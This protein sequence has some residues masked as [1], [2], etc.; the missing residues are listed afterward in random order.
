MCVIMMQKPTSPCERFFLH[1]GFCIFLKVREKQW[2]CSKIIPKS[3]VILFKILNNTLKSRECV[4]QNACE[5]MY[6]CQGVRENLPC[7]TMASFWWQTVPS[8]IDSALFRT[9]FW[10]S[11]G[12][13]LLLLL[14]WFGTNMLEFFGAKRVPVKPKC[15]TM[16]LTQ[17][18]ILELLKQHC[19]EDKVN[20]WGIGSF[21]FKC[22][23]CMFFFTRLGNF[24]E[25]FFSPIH[26][27]S[28][29][30]CFFSSA[31][32]EDETICRYI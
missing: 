1:L 9:V 14:L 21:C 29:L 28:P 20:G 10:V 8:T 3:M 16:I 4:M 5:C 27:Y 7:I 26:S 2:R 15:I 17:R 18:S 32:K 12:P 25:F 11:F 13:L 19:H 30:E 6:V 23:C 22:G 31:L 24:G